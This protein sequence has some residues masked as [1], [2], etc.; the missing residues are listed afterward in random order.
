MKNVTF[1]ALVAFLGLIQACTTPARS[2][3]QE[4]KYKNTVEEKK[5]HYPSWRAGQRH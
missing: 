2:V 3:A 5:H 4:E 1:V